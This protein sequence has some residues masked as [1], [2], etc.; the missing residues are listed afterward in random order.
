M[1]VILDHDTHVYTNTENG[2]V[3]TSV[4]TFI[5]KYKKP[6]DKDKWS[7]YVAQRDGLSQEEVLDKWSTITTTAQNR[8]TNVHLIMENYIK[9][10]KIEK[11][12][13]DF[14][15]SFIKKTNGIILPDSK[16][17]SEE[18]LYS[19][20]HK[21]A[22]TADLIV[23]NKNIF[24]VMDFKTNKKFNYTNKYNEYFFEPI[25]Y[26]PQ[27]EFTTYTIQLSIYAR[28]H[29]LLTGKKCAG[30]KVFYLREFKDK[31][32]WQDIPMI[33]MKD[34]VDKLFKDKLSKD[35]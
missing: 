16:I 26:L 14:V 31:T 18:L 15:D 10:R 27:C 32:F 20:E 21:L 5:G 9:E 12:Y 13:E 19:H 29:E 6:F 11:G 35:N 1:P 34:T 33:Y 8:G 24:H 25:D 2:E 30:M 23:E 7:K 17:L 22:G 28:M 3:Y 4:T